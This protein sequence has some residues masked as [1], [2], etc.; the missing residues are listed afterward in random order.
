MEGET[1][2]RK[3]REEGRE[4]RS[5]QSWGRARLGLESDA[6]LMEYTQARV[7]IVE[8]TPATEKQFYKTSS[9]FFLNSMR[10]I[11]I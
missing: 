3:H 10:E 5:T 9:L 11:N 6:V 1:E 8:V 2:E 4:E 7:K